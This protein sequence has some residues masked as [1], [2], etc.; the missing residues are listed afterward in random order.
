MIFD[1]D[2]YQGKKGP[3]RLMDLREYWT[4]LPNEEKTDNPRSEEL[5]CTCPYCMHQAYKEDP[6][7]H[8]KPYTKQKL[9]LTRDFAKGWCHRCDSTYITN[10]FNI[11]YQIPSLL[12]EVGTPSLDDLEFKVTDEKYPLEKF[13]TFSKDLPDDMIDLLYNR[14]PYTMNF[15]EE[16]DFRFIEKNKLAIPFYWK[17]KLLM[18]QVWQKF[19]TPKYRNPRI[20]NKPFYICGPIKKDAILV[21]GVFD[22]VAERTLHPDK[23]PIALLGSTATFAQSIMLRSMF[24]NSITIRMDDSI[25]S[26][27]LYNRI[28]R[29]FEFTDLYI[30]E[31]NGE[32]SEEEL[33]R[34]V[35]W[36]KS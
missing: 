2:E 29:D 1:Y 31:S 6:S 33:C 13:D 32:D 28:K 35:G 18:Y 3:V 8:G 24:F 11:H 16:L 36:K 25:L 15:Y 20:S 7:Y 21:E 9:Y 14:N 23:T 5:T 34:L 27:K 26:Y 10:E 30:I 4:L 17:D 12:K 22:A 19:E